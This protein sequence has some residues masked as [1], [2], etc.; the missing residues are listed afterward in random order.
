M[1]DDK[2]GPLLGWSLGSGMKKRP[3]EELVEFP[4]T[5]TFKA[6]GEAT[7]EFVASLLQKVGEVLGRE[8]TGEEHSVRASRK[9]NYQSITMNLFVTSSEQV[10][11]IYAVINADERVRYML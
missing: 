8:I 5:Y 4:C 10:Y 7:D 2:A 9:G 1:A 11:D 3:I 6:V